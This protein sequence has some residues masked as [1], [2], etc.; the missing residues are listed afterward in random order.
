MILVCKVYWLGVFVLEGF[1]YVEF[2]FV[3]CWFGF[4]GFGFEENGS[5]CKTVV[6]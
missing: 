1:E 3:E 6:V 5:G 2:A 4:G